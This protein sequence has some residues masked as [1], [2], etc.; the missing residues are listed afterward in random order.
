MKLLVWGSTVLVLGRLLSGLAG[1][2]AIE[3]VHWGLVLL[4]VV[5]EVLAWLTSVA[6]MAVAVAC[7][8]AA[9]TV[10]PGSVACCSHCWCWCCYCTA[11]R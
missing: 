7:L 11:V 2:V 5:A 4:A 8:L 9:V 3:H 6:V 10:A 1:D